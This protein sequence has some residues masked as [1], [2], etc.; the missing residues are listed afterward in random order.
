MNWIQ[1]A[2]AK[3]YPEFSE[4]EEEEEEEGGVAQGH[5]EVVLGRVLVGAVEASGNGDCCFGS[6]QRD[7]DRVSNSW[8]EFK[9]IQWITL[10]SNQLITSSLPDS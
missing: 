8:L 10:N 7:T 5:E 4:G 6:H 3:H 1:L 9:S 2:L